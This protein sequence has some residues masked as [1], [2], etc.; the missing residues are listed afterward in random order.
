MFLHGGA[1]QG[2][3]W[4]LVRPLL[5]EL[6]HRTIAPTLP[7]AGT[8][9]RTDDWADVVVSAVSDLVDLGDLYLVGHSYSG[10]VLPVVASRIPVKR[11][12]FLGAH[13]PAPGVPYTTYMEQHPEYSIGPF[14]L[15]EYHDGRLLLSWE[16]ARGFFF[17]DCEEGLAK[18]CA[19]TAVQ[20]A[21]VERALS[22]RRMAQRA[23]V[24]HP[25]AR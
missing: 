17:P 23:V 6:G 2:W 3:H 10:V 4:R 21:C 5:E 11:M 8:S 7:M 24:V 14:D 16:I 19:S 9:K 1:H 15:Y 22:D 13:V 25:R 18:L 12:I 20:H